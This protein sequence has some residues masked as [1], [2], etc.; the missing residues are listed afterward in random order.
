MEVTIPTLGESISGGLLADWK[1]A[2]GQLVEK[3]APL[4]MLDTDK[5]SLELTAPESGKVAHLAK[6]GERVS[7]GQVVAKIEG[8]TASIAAAVAVLPTVVPERTRP[9]HREAITPIRQRIAERMV[10]SHQTTANTTTFADV[11]MLAVMQTRQKHAA[12]FEEKHGVKLGYMPFFIK[13]VVYALQKMPQV[14]TRWD[15]DAIV[16]ND[17]YDISIAMGAERGLVTPVICDCDKLSLGE[18]EQQL[19]HFAEKAKTGNL[20]LDELNGGVFTISNGGVYGSMLST[21]LLNPPQ[22]AVLGIHAIEER[23]VALGGQVVIRPRMYAALS[24]DHRLLD[25]REAVS[26]LQLIKQVIEDPAFL[27]LQ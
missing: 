20:A 25:G 21:P 7:V 8:G 15:D 14:N 12:F 17:Y 5:V 11:D 23:P 9:T 18:L 27:L 26:F 1:I 2:D 19:L 10:A 13:A 6:A 22:A 16:Y 24:Y 4:F 3:G